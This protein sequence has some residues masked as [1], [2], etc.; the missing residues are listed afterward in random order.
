MYA[1]IFSLHPLAIINLEYW[2]LLVS[3]VFEQLNLEEEV[4]MCLTWGVIE[5]SF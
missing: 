5:D 1:Y 3:T 2:L 4:T